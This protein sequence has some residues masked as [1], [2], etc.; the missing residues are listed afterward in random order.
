MSVAIVMS[1]LSV[2]IALTSDTPGDEVSPDAAILVKTPTEI[3]Y[4]IL[5]TSDAP[6]DEVSFDAAI[7]V[8]NSDAPFET[9][10]RKTPYEFRSAGF[11]ASAMFR[12]HGDIHIRVEVLG[13]HEGKQVSRYIASGR[14]IVVGDNLVH[15]TEDENSGFLSAF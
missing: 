4:T 12:T 1:T 3:E 7:L 9:V 15:D 11:G 10:S 2:S 8:K 13:I 6:G 14:A 5:V